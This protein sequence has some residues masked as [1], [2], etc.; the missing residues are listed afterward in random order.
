MV[1]ILLGSANKLSFYLLHGNVQLNVLQCLYVKYCFV[2]GPFCYNAG[3][4]LYCFVLMSF[5]CCVVLII[6]VLCCAVLRCLMLY[7]ELCPVV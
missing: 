1:L 2:H 7:C 5:F 4:S 6:Y 3:F